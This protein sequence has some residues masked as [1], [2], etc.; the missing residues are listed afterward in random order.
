MPKC[1]F[2]PKLPFLQDVGVFFLVSELQWRAV[3][4]AL[5]KS[6]EV[7]AVREAALPRDFSDG[8]S[9]AHEERVRSLD[10]EIPD[11]FSHG[12]SGFLA[13]DAEEVP[14]RHAG[15]GGQFL[16]GGVEVEILVQVFPDDGDSGTVSRGG[17]DKLLSGSCEADDQRHEERHGLEVLS[18]QFAG[19]FIL[20][21][22]DEEA[23]VLEFLRIQMESRLEELLAF[24]FCS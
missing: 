10:S 15:P 6:A 11:V 4:D 16:L 19:E 5:E 18:G 1:I 24:L 12:L 13:E 22:L 3:V 9:G 21:F 23:G 7:V 14:G 8:H 20:Q 2:L 17:W